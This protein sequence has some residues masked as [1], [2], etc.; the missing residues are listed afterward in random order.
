L[1]KEL[2]TQYL[3]KEEYAYVASGGMHFVA[4]AYA[5]EGYGGDAVATIDATVP[6]ASSTYDRLGETWT[7]EA[8]LTGESP[9]TFFTYS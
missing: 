2:E 4:S 3:F 9:L 1:Q 5:T 6:S 8:E 7:A